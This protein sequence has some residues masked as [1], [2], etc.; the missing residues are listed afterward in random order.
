[1]KRIISSMLILFVAVP[2][3]AADEILFKGSFD[4]ALAAAA[5][6]GKMLL[7]DFYSAG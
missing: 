2:L 3:F 7:I 1:M 4:D 6:N 5:K